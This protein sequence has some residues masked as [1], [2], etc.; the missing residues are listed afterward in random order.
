M[1]TLYRVSIQPHSPVFSLL[2]CPFQRPAELMMS[3]T[4]EPKALDSRSDTARPSGLCP[5]A[6]G[7][8]AVSAARMKPGRTPE[9][10]PS[11]LRRARLP[12][13]CARDGRERYHF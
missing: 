2:A 13:A 12:G 11:G 10:Y 9:R 8:P 5:V 6:V 1:K 4:E 7:G 3:A